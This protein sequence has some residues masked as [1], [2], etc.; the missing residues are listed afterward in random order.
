MPRVMNFM[1]VLSAMLTVV[2]WSYDANAARKARKAHTAHV[3]HAARPA[4]HDG[5]W[6]VLIV[7]QRGNCDRAY[8]YN[9]AVSNGRITYQG[10]A[11]VA[12]S[13]SVARSGFVR[14]SIK[15]GSGG[16]NGSGHLSSNVGH[17]TW[18][19]SGSNGTCAGRWE[20][21]KL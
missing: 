16:A 4:G 13:G 6:S 17:G 21:Q 8:R 9:L 20:A 3:T 19:G 12:V 10:G 2:G 18:R 5:S 1:L 11:P 7:T 14:V 15:G